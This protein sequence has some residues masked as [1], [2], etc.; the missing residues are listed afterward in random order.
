MSVSHMWYRQNDESHSMIAWYIHGDNDV[1]LCSLCQIV[2]WQWCNMHNS[3]IVFKL[4][5][6]KNVSKRGVIYF[7]LSDDGNN[8]T[9]CQWCCKRV[10]AFR[11]NLLRQIWSILIMI[12]EDCFEMSVHIP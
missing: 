7:I 3:L 8:S 12:L 1:T 10:L 4:F 11:W 5:W 2:F 9:T 6:N